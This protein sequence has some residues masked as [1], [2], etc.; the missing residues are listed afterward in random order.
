MPIDLRNPRVR[1]CFDSM[2]QS[3]VKT[4]THQQLVR[5]HHRIENCDNLEQAAEVNSHMCGRPMTESQNQLAS[6]D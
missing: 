5:W 2:L 6:P 1:Y 4:L 3:A